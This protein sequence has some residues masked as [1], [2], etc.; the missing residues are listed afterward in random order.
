MGISAKKLN[1]LSGGDGPRDRK[2][3]SILVTLMAT[4]VAGT[5]AGAA[6]PARRGRPNPQEWRSTGYL[7]IVAN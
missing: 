5:R 3:S 4:T 6:G 1:A 7:T 2:L